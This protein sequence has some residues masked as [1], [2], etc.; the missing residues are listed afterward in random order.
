M[1][2]GRWTTLRGPHWGLQHCTHCPEPQTSDDGRMTVTGGTSGFH[3]ILKVYAVLRLSRWR[4]LVKHLPANAGDLRAR[5]W[6]SGSGR[7]PGGG[8]GNPLQCSCLEHLMDRGAWWA[9]VHGVAES[10]TQ[11]KL[12]STHAR[13]CGVDSRL[14][15]SQCLSFSLVP[16]C[17]STSGSQSTV[18]GPT[19][20]APTQ[21]P[22][23][24]QAP[25]SRL[26][27]SVLNSPPVET[28][29]GPHCPLLWRLEG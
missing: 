27:E 12:L 29:W 16:V 10:Q 20:S 19:A 28:I 22:A 13:P 6:T 15:V 5:G 3:W 4:W 21:N 24:S 14:L 23:H 18:W 11:L 17:L 26:G 8:H 2:L 7:S 9:A 1:D 25:P